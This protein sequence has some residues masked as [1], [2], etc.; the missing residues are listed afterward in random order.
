[1]EVGTS[2]LGASLVLESVDA[3]VLI[4]TADVLIQTGDRVRDTSKHNSGLMMGTALSLVQGLNP[5]VNVLW[6]NGKT[7]LVKNKRSCL[8][9]ISADST[10]AGAEEVPKGPDTESCMKCK[11][12]VDS[13]VDPIFFCATC[14][15][16]EPG[17][18]LS[19]ARDMGLRVPLNGDVNQDEFVYH[20]NA[21]QQRPISGKESFI[22]NA[23][24]G[25]ETITRGRTDSTCSVVDVLSK[26]GSAI[27]ALQ[28]LLP[29]VYQQN[30]RIL[31]NVCERK[32]QHLV[33]TNMPI[34][35]QR[36]KQ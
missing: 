36:C 9:L 1:M 4:Q 32:L 31:L 12:L 19:C 30:L 29:D 7:S 14:P 24:S 28:V 5:R 26:V 13:D 25:A 3:D 8:V 11:S 20:C 16:G 33:H 6:G 15:K 21:C 34:K 22:I 27:G 17:L 18:H 10:G 35:K 23:D 2:V